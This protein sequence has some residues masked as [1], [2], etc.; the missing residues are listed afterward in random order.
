[1]DFG[2]RYTLGQNQDTPALLPRQSF[3]CRL[4]ESGNLH[5]AAT[6]TLF[7][8]LYFRIVKASPGFAP[9]KS[10]SPAS[11]GASSRTE[12]RQGLERKW[13]RTGLAFGVV[14]LWCGLLFPPFVAAERP[15]FTTVAAKASDAQ[16]APQRPSP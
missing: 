6:R 13:M 14:M 9:S 11:R 10:C 3:A 12:A 16:T 1:M 7:D 15:A 8:A 2:P 4:C 5:D